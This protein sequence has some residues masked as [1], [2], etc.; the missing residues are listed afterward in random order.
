MVQ[1][2]LQVNG[3]RERIS[4]QAAK[5]PKVLNQ[6][7]PAWAEPDSATPLALFMTPA[8]K[9]GHLELVRAIVFETIRNLT[10]ATIAQANA[11]LASGDALLAAG[12]YKAAYAAY[13]KAYKAAAS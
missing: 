13:R 5:T 10:G 9:G 11:T 12:K 8:S 2:N 7:Y 4:R 1:F 3:L 6:I